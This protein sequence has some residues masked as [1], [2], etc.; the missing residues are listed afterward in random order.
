M[1]FIRIFLTVFLLLAAAAPSFSQDTREQESRRAALEKEIAQLEQQIAEN[2]SRSS[3]ALND[4]TL[5]R[6]QVETRKALVAESERQIRMIDDSIT[7]T[8]ANIAGLQARIDT[9]TS[10]FGRLVRSAYKNRDARVWY[11]YILT[12]RNFGQATRRYSYLKNLSS[13]LNDEAAQVKEM[14]AGLELELTRLDSLKVQATQLRDAQQKELAGLR[15][16][17]KRSDDLVSQLKRYRTRYQRQLETKRKQVEDLNREIER[18]IAEYIAEQKAR[19]EEQKRAAAARQGEQ[20]AAEA[21]APVVDYE[22]AAEFESNKGKLPW[23]ADGP[24]LE[25][26]GRHNHP[27]YTNIVMPFSNGI[28][29]GLAKGSAVRAVFDGEVKNVIA[30][31]GYNMCVLVQ[32]GSYF[33]FYCKLGQVSVK[34]GDKVSTGSIIGTVDTIDG[35]TQ[36][37]FQIWKEKSPQNPEI[38]LRSK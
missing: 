15:A 11:V 22:L 18:I 2:I 8:T 9:L 28:S 17:E 4:L 14:R 34:A 19:E 24:V 5:I 38:W 26:F 32:H 23:P 25:K 7:L 6:K 37:H 16:E 12:S 10:Y 30:M 20:A 1:K 31:P 3:S 13:T 35:Q 27:V 29:I 21:P 33:T 36:L